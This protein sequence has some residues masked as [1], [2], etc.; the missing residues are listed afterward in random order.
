MQVEFFGGSNPQSLQDR[1][2][3]WLKEHDKIATHL[4]VQTQAPG[5][6]TRPGAIL[7]TLWYSEITGAPQIG[8]RP[9]VLGMP[10]PGFRHPGRS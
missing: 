6:Q 9:I 5:T 4:I 8:G 10:A 2:N 1:I 3:A 7:I